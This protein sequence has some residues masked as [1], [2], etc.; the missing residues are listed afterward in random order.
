MMK[1][2]PASPQRAYSSRNRLAAERPEQGDDEIGNPDLEDRLQLNRAGVKEAKESVKHRF[3]ARAIANGLLGG[4]VGACFGGP[5]GAMMA[6]G[7]VVGAGT[8]LYVAWNQSWRND[9]GRVDIDLDGETRTT[10]FFGSPD[11]FLRTP[12]EMQMEMAAAD[13]PP[14]GSGLMPDLAGLDLADALAI[15]PAQREN[16]KSLEAERR[17]LAP[18]S[19]ANED[20]GLMLTLVNSRA[21]AALLANERSV[22]KIDGHYQDEAEVLEYVASNP[23]VSQVA[24]KNVEIVRRNFQYDLIPLSL[25]SS[26][27]SSTGTGLPPGITAVPSDAK[28]VSAIISA[29]TQDVEAIFPNKNSSLVNKSQQGFARVENRDWE[30]DRLS[31]GMG[32][33]EPVG[34]LGA[35][36]GLAIGGAVA[37]SLSLVGIPSIGIGIATGIVG[38]ELG[39]QVK[40]L[41]KPNHVK[42]L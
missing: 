22:Y 2:T 25:D 6:L 16:L 7:A 38:R 24:Q 5:V 8:G 20:G 36:V 17:L 33:V 29:D 31:L 26:T 28:N 41:L 11:N 23:N 12:E 9:V 19:K 42:P 3:K 27:S 18:M 1:V 30:S 32:W 14:A 4:I 34:A 40:K 37:A 39:C 15:E 21:A 35:L 13:P 10:K